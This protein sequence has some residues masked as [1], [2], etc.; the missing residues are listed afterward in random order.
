MKVEV[1]WEK[2]VCREVEQRGEAAEKTPL[3]AYV[4]DPD[5]GHDEGLVPVEPSSS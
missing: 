1:P 4:R 5:S 3:G 2:M